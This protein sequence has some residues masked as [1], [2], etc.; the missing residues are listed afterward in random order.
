MRVDQDWFPMIDTAAN[1]GHIYQWTLGFHVSAF[2][3]ARKRGHAEVV[4]LLLRR[5]GPL[6][7]FLDS[8]WCGDD[9]RADA[10]LAVDPHLVDRAPARALRQVADAARNNNTA[11]ASAMLRRGFPV[12]AL[13]QHAATP[14]HWAAF[15]G[16]SDMLEEVLR[17]NP[18]LDAR[19]R[20]FQGTPMDW[21]IHGALEPWRGI[22]TGRHAACA[23]LLL[24]AGAQVDEASLP[25]GHD[26]VDQV[27]REHLLSE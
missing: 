12:T 6:D 24:G 8:L 7:R 26:A 20:Q 22:S 10:A 16:N 25:T 19:D 4:D 14:L 21:L 1:G 5:A 27:L 3:I 18:P 9:A 23:R 13:S 11:A 15:H 17:H 2:D